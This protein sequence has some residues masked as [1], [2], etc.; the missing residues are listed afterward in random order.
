MLI[1]A[2]LISQAIA[3]LLSLEKLLEGLMS[4]F[5]VNTDARVFMQASYCIVPLDKKL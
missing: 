3:V 4:A 2:S 1:G 5:P